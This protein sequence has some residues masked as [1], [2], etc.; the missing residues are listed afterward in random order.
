ALAARAAAAGGEYPS[1]GGGPAERIRSAAG[2]MRAAAGALKGSDFAAAL[3]AQEE[4]LREL[5]KGGKDLMDYSAAMS[6]MS[7]PGGASGGAYSQRSAGG[8]ERVPE[9]GGYVPPE[10]IRRRVL[11][12]LREPYPEEKK[13]AVEDYL[14]GVGR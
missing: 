1:L 4:A 8:R 9:G 12:S 14:R 5:E 10:E 6:A 7:R 11:E 2:H 13:K 3:A